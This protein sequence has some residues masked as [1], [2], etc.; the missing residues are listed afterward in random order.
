M[1]PSAEVKNL[2]EPEFNWGK[3]RGRGGK[4][5]TV[6][7]Y[8]SFTYDEVDYTLHDCV[9][10][11]VQ[12]EPTPYIGK[13]IKIWEDAGESKKV[14]IQWFFRPS[15]ISYYLRDMEVAENELFFAT[16]EG[17]GLANINPLEAIA[18]K[19]NVVCISNDSRNPQPSV[20]EVQMADYVFYRLFDVKNCL[21]LDKMDR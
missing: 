1:P 21:I 9:Y 10:M 18:G 4:M 11:Y 12:D 17:T 16:G 5:K 3:K 7:F 6:Q 13:L 20:E 15:E 8:E 14:K 2:D 19:C